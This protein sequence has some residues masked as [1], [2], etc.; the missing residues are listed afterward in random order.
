MRFTVLASGSNGN[1]T[2]I[3]SGKCRVL[4]D[5]GISTRRIVTALRDRGIS[6]SS[7]TAILLTHEHAD[8]ITGLEVFLKTYKIPVYSGAPTL[9]YLSMYAGLRPFLSL[10][11]Q[12]C[13]DDPFCFGELDIMPFTAH[14]DA[15]STLGFVLAGSGVKVGY[16]MDNS[17]YCSEITQ[18]LR[19]C[20][21]LLLESNFCRVGLRES[22]YP[23]YLQARI[24]GPG[25]HASNQEL[26]RWLEH[27][28]D[29]KAEK[30]IL[31]HL[32]GNSNKPEWAYDLAFNALDKRGYTP[33]SARGKMLT[34]LPKGG[35]TGWVEV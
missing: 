14:H 8:H 3:E 12:I 25:G 27:D 32:S 11:R 18:H 10:C 5:C 16:V 1:C 7:I 22:S 24:S 26:S 2:L 20:D 29:G 35:Y 15:S 17:R 30:V 6:P 33:G 23:Y 4:I 31:G 13:A 34:V 28:F 19:D 21:A 9:E